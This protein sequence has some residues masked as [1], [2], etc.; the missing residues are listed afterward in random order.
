MNAMNR[1]NEELGALAPFVDAVQ[2]QPVADSDSQSAQ[3]KLM[4]RLAQAKPKPQPGSR[5]GWLTAAGVAGLAAILVLPTLMIGPT[6]AFADVVKHFRDFTTM[7]MLMDV[8]INGGQRQHNV[9]TVNR[10]GDLRSDME[11][12]M[13]VVLNRKEGRILTLLH[14]LKLVQITPFDSTQSSRED[15]LRWIDEMRDY[16]G[17]AISLAQTR[18]IDGQLAHGY[19]LHT[20]GQSMTVWADAHGLPLEMQVD[21][22]STMKLSFRFE[23]DR[24][25]DASAFS[26]EVPQG[27]TLTEGED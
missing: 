5:W 24:P 1:S 15:S 6:P 10:D 20:E 12:S 13:S 9:I 21:Q 14:E 27:Y 7:R 26:T 8:E 25:V 3:S 19:Q 22:G 2:S 23:F 11:D 4:Q 16:Q 18:T 17:T